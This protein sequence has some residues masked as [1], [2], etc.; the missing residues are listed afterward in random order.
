MA[1]GGAAIEGTLLLNLSCVE[2]LLTPWIQTKVPDRNS[3]IF[4]SRI[5][6]LKISLHALRL[7]F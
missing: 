7:G 3:S 2:D 5:Y 6:L 1:A 4:W